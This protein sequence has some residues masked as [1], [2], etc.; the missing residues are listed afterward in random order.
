[1]CGPDWVDD[2]ERMSDPKGYDIKTA[3]GDIIH[4]SPMDLSELDGIK[5][6]KQA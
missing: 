4:V 5:K 3:E 2:L 6:D 1:M